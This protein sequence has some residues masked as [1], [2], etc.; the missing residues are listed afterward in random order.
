M[1]DDDR[2][3]LKKMYDAYGPKDIFHA[4]ADFDEEAIES[5]QI[6]DAA[7]VPEIRKCVAI[8]RQLAE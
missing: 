5:G 6:D 3:A 4:L 7:E 8:L 1:L 2:A